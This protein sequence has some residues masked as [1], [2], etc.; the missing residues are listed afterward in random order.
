MSPTSARKD[1]EELSTKDAKGRESAGR[2][3]LSTG[4]RSSDGP[5][6][7]FCQ[8]QSMRHPESF[9][10]FVCFVPPHRM[11]PAEGVAPNGQP[12]QGVKGEDCPLGVKARLEFRVSEGSRW[13]HAPTELRQNFCYRRGW[14]AGWHGRSMR[15]KS[16]Y[17]DL[18]G[19]N[20][21]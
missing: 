14:L 12:L 15:Q 9:A 10:L 18:D 4:L 11:V 8:G 21:E 17:P 3:W 6:S 5:V 7:G 2:K 13:K 20:D 16:S 19:R 1:A